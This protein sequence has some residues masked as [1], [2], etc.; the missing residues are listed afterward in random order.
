MQKILNALV[1]GISDLGLEGIIMPQ[2]AIANRPRIELYLAGIEP[3]GIDNKNP[4]TG[5]LGWERITFNAVFKSEGSHIQWVTDAILAL[6]K[7]QPLTEKTMRLMVEADKTYYLEAAWVRRTPGRFE[8]PN[9]EE[10]SM[11][12]RYTEGWEVSVAYPA[13]IIG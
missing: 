1:K 10:S 11:P 12:L 13:H 2:Q 8:Y 3:A 7:L 9:E 6:R 5:N 4:E